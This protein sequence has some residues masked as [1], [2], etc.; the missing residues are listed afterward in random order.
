MSKNNWHKIKFTQ[1]YF[2][3]PTYC[4]TPKAGI[5]FYQITAISMWH[6]AWIIYNCKHIQ[7]SKF[8][9]EKNTHTHTHIK[10]KLMFTKIDIFCINNFYLCAWEIY[11]LLIFAVFAYSSL[12]YWWIGDCDAWISLKSASATGKTI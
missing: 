10:Y 5:N 9:R 7:Q 4:N 8:S 6:S 12:I 11:G 2:D 3:F 1:F